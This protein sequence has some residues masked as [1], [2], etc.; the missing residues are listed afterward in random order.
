M[1]IYNGIL[2]SHKEEQDWFICRD[3]DGPGDCHTKWSTSE[4]KNN[5]ILMHIC[6]IQKINIDDLTCKAEIET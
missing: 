1:H 5:H 4:G 3:I 6:G 2:L